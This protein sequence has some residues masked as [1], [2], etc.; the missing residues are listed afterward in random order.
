M[1][2]IGRA[3][4]TGLCVATAVVCTASPAGADPVPVWD[5]RTLAAVGSDTTQYM[6]DGVAKVAPDAAGLASWNAQ[7]AVGSTVTIRTKPS[8]CEFPRP[9]G[10]IEGRLALSASEPG[11]AFPGCVDVL[12][13]GIP[14]V[15]TPG[16]TYTKI[17]AGVDGLA[18]AKHSDS[19]LPD[20]I[21]FPQA[22]R[23]YRCFEDSIAGVSVVPLVVHPRSD[24]W[25]SWMQRMGI[26][27]GE[28]LN[29][30]YPCLYDNNQYVRPPAPPND[31]AALT[32]LAYVM[33]YS[34]ANF[35][36]QSRS[37]TIESLTGV[38]VP[39]LRGPVYLTGLNS[40]Q[41]PYNRTTLALNLN[42]PLTHEVSNT[43]RTDRLG[44]GEL[45]ALVAGCYTEISDGAV[46]YRLAELFGFGVTSTCGTSRT[47]GIP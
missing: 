1:D 20:N 21:T 27:T 34:V 42:Y 33:P 38:T 39:D 7:P 37:A 19:D 41:Q 4:A 3:L 40:F 13:S 18:L 32:D 30:D 45:A 12:R 43:I 47:S 16:N 10:H 35:I 11:G 8:G 31:G 6:M 15:T 17:I 5:F 24:V 28:L 22:Q 36:A 14:P 23:I 46:T 2:V 29:F 25:Q 44:T 26:T 9:F